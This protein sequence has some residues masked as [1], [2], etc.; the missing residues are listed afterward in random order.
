[1]QSST[2]VR[3]GSQIESFTYIKA[4]NTKDREK[5]TTCVGVSRILEKECTGAVTG[6]KME[7]TTN[8][9]TTKKHAHTHKKKK[10]ICHCLAIFIY[11]QV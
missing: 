4:I 7:Q 2:A 11:L 3:E 8:K 6:K 5:Q 9:K 1:M 10:I